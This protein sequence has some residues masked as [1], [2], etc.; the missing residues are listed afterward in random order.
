MTAAIG[1]QLRLLGAF[2]LIT[3]ATPLAL[4]PASQRLIAYVA[5]QDLPVSRQHLAGVLWGDVPESRAAANLRNGL[6]RLPRRGSRRPLVQCDST[7]VRL[8][9]DIWVDVRV[10][11][12]QLR[13]LEPLA[14]ESELFSRDLLP[15][16]GEDWLIMEQERYR[17]LRLH[18]LEQLCTLH[19]QA[20]RFMAA[21]QAGLTAVS[22]EPL[23]ESAHRRVVEVH[24]AEGNPAEA[25]RQ[26]QSYRQLLRAELGL[27]P[28]PAIRSLVAHLLGRPADLPQGNP[29]DT[30]VGE[31]ETNNRPG[32]RDHGE[33]GSRRV[34]RDQWGRRHG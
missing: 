9:E 16:W 33:R 1:T 10:A 13:S 2:S 18:A 12:S 21:L 34:L 11:E 27:I 32:G 22:A 20:G 14:P 15:A 30:Q 5:L 4:P 3:D 7:T 19:Y 25:L 29:N 24:L 17:Q 8:A 23:R 26:Y 31:G 28:S 6:F